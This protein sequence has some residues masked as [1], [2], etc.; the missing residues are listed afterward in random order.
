MQLTARPFPKDNRV[1]QAD[2]VSHKLLGD[3]LEV[4]QREQQ[5]RDQRTLEQRRLTQRER[6]Q[7]QSAMG[8]AW[9]ETAEAA[10]P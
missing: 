8:D 10:T 9:G 4:I 6:T 5:A 1:R 7:L 3:T 2:I